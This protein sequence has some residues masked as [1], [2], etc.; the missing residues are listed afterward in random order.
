MRKTKFNK[1]KATH[2]LSCPTCGSINNTR[3]IGVYDSAGRPDKW[4]CEC[5]RCGKSFY[6]RQYG[7]AI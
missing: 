2:D 6:P 3:I 7:V 1:F 4:L 5:A